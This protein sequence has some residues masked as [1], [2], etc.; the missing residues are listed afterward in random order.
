MEKIRKA[1]DSFLN[2][3]EKLFRIIEDARQP[4]G[5][6]TKSGQ[7]LVGILSIFASSILSSLVATWVAQD[8]LRYSFPVVVV[9]AFSLLFLFTTILQTRWLRLQ[10]NAYSIFAIMLSVIIIQSVALTWLYVDTRPP[11]VYLLFDA[12]ARTEPNYSSIV[13]KIIETTEV[14][15]PN[16]K[17][18]LRVYGGNLSGQSDCNDTT[19][20]I[21]P[22]PI[23]KYGEEINKV[24]SSV[25]PNGHASLTIAVLET[26]KND[27][28][29][30]R[31]P[32]KLIVVTSGI[33][34]ECEPPKGGIFEAI[35]N[36][37]KANTRDDITIIIFSVGQL[38]VEEQNVLTEYALA[39]NGKHF[40]SENAD[41]LLSLI[42][43]PPS[44]ISSYANL[45]QPTPTP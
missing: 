31:G 9:V 24:L 12:T 33:D 44:Y 18:G 34:V 19:Q 22:I 36:D 5:E 4:T 45:I 42:V 1:I 30:Y 35:A 23:E 21:K 3:I 28:K 25:T 8:L 38:S 20:L 7:E 13:Q 14:Q 16:S 26:L 29:Q 43:A 39:Y 2:R 41:G 37:I 32:I 11:T 40:N 6:K 10:L 27:L 15:P 17:G